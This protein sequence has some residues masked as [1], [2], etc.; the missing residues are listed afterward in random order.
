MSTIIERLAL[1]RKE[2]K[3][4]GLSAYIIP[5]SD[6]HLS[7][8]TPDRFKSRAWISGFNG[9]AGT[10]VVTLDKA[11][12][13]TDSRY[14][15]QAGEQLKDSSIEL[16]KMGVPGVPTIEG[17]LA[18]E[19]PAGAVVGADGACRS[20]AEADDTERKLA[21]YGIE[22]RLTQDLIERVWVD[23][24]ALPDQ[25]L[26]LPPEEYSGASAKERIEAVRGKLRAQGANAT[27]ITMIDELAW[28]FN[29]RGNDV[30]FNPVAVGFG[31]I[32]E[33][34]AV[35][36]VDPAKVPEEVRSYLMGNGVTLKGYTELDGFIAALPA[37][38]RLLVDTKRITYHIY[39]LIP[40][41]CR[42]IEG[43]SALTQLKAIK[44]GTEIACL[45]KV[46]ARD[47]ASLTRFFKWLEEALGRGETYTEYELGIRLNEFRAKD[48]KF[49][50]D[51]FGTIC[52]YL[53]NGAI[54]HYSA[55]KDTAATVRP[56]GVLLLDSGGQYVDG[57]TDITRTVAL[58]AP[59][60]ELRTD[61]TLVLKGHIQ[62]ALVQY[63]EGTRGSQLDILA[64]HA[65]WQQGLN[66]G[67]GTGHGV[68]FFLNVHEGP[69]NIRMEVNP[70]PLELGMITSNEPGLYR[71]GKYGIRIENLVIT[72]LREETEFGRFF[73][74]ETVTLCYLDNQLVR[75]DLLTAEEIAWYDA[76][77]E[78]VYQT[79]APLLSSDEAAWLRSKT[80]PL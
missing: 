16:F 59:S 64:R 41:H 52:G 1:L 27:I 48:D 11:G 35:I 65:L 49:Y 21:V 38:V 6:A 75:K 80:L 62:L 17:F 71:S 36:F 69:Q 3:A 22:Y 78:R 51:S 76:Y 77:Q 37:E 61:Y 43:V 25:P 13:W 46:M 57:T 32:G 40:A 39:S 54:V 66:Y 8:Y 42:K 4:A 33:K 34:E 63:L 9:S 68:G 15:L 58:S 74:F 10:V 29:V 79:I 2:M 45:R 7:E 53:G 44:N 67:H 50:G 23:R 47:G 20:F 60:E 26:F 12:L 72:E 56:E 14:F 55:Q 24:P 73:G 18:A 30:S 70:T 31:Y 5:S 19:L 28:V